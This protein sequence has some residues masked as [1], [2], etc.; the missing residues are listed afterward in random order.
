MYRTYVNIMYIFCCCRCCLYRIIWFLFYMW[1][2]IAMD[3]KTSNFCQ[4]PSSNKSVKCGRNNNIVVVRLPSFYLWGCWLDI[5]LHCI[6]VFIVQPVAVSVWVCV[7][8]SDLIMIMSF[9]DEKDV[10][11]L[12]CGC[13]TNC[14]NARIH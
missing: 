9:A 2:L 6:I 11:L 5:Q 7:C 3:P 13:P 1:S 4:W 10:A 12:L 8:V 14:K